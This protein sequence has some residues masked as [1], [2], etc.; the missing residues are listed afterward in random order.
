LARPSEYAAVSSFVPPNAGYAQVSASDIAAPPPD[1][2]RAPST[3]ANY[4]SAHI[5]PPSSQTEDL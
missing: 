5:E 1:Y 4:N 3:T 2:D